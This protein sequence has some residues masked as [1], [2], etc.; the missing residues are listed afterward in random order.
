MSSD[1]IQTRRSSLPAQPRLAK[2]ER[3]WARLDFE[4]CQRCTVEYDHGDVVEIT[5]DTDEN[6]TVSRDCVRDYQLE[7]GDTVFVEH[8]RGAVSGAPA[9][10]R[11]VLGEVVKVEF[12]RSLYSDPDER[13]LFLRDL[14][15]YG[16]PPAAKWK[17]RAVV[18]AYK[19]MVFTPP[20]YLLFPAVVDRVDFE[21]FVEVEFSD[22]GRSYVPVTLIERPAMQPGEIAYACTG[23]AANVGDCWSPCEILSRD[24]DTLTLREIGGA[25]FDIH[26]SQVAATPRG[27]RMW[28]G[29]LEKIAPGGGS[30]LPASPDDVHIVRTDHW[31]LADDN[32]IRKE[33]IDRLLTSDEELMWSLAKPAA[34]EPGRA[35]LWRDVPCFRWVDGGIRCSSPSEEQLAKMIEIAMELDANVL[36]HDG[37]ELH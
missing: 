20:L 4:F 32:P 37:N 30:L 8:W 33:D 5:L 22:G 16:E 13:T 10:V 27:Y 3:T 25:P 19:M 26:I 35:I 24:T 34:G 36:A 2:G 21:N 7:P 9:I 6:H 15:I 23:H 29:K 12:P 17:P 14:R 28:D 1:H 11:D 18:F 31:R